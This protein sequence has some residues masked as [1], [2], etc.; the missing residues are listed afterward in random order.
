MANS[1]RGKELLI[2]PRNFCGAE[3]YN[4]MLSPQN[5]AVIL[6]IVNF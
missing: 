6:L 3:K 2:M 4:R 1:E 5:D